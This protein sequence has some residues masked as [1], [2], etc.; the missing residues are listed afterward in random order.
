MVTPKVTILN[1][2][3]HLLFR[4]E[5]SQHVT[6]CVE[7]MKEP[8]ETWSQEDSQ[9]TLLNLVT[10]EPDRYYMAEG[11]KLYCQETW[12]ATFGSEGKA[13]VERYIDGVVGYY[14]EC[15]SADNHAVR[16]AACHC[17]A[18][19]AAKIDRAVLAPHVQTLLRTL[20][21][22]FEDDSW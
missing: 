1:N 14:V 12:R 3:N 4:G 20:L 6:V 9:K 17:I 13:M 21:E 11:V 10:P 18:E 15:T 19:L 8:T 22:C 2:N 7:L 5:T 16:E